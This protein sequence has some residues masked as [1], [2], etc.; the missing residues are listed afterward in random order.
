MNDNEPEIRNREAGNLLLTN[1]PPY[2]IMGLET[3]R[4]G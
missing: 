2:A 4:I 3:A 1:N